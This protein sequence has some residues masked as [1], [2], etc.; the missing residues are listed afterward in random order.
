MASTNILNGTMTLLKTGT[1]ASESAYA[2]STSASLSLSMDTRDISNKGS[3]G[4]RELLE[5]GMSWSASCEGLYAVEDASGSVKNYNELYDLLISRAT[6]SILMTS[7][8]TGNYSYQGNGYCTSVEQSAPMEDNMT[9]SAS[10]EGTGELSVS[11][12]S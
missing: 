8:T 5:A 10:F 11:T 4:W 12:D 2:F 6:T 1:A 3:S 9:F 7:D